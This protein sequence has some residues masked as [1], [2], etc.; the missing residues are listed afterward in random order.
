MP[1][2]SR[3]ITPWNFKRSCDEDTATDC[4]PPK[5]V[6][7]TCRCTGISCARRIK[8]DWHHLRNLTT[9]CFFLRRGDKNSRHDVIEDALSSNDVALS[10]L[11]A[12]GL[13]PYSA[14]TWWRNIGF[15]E[16]LR[17]LIM[18]FTLTC[19]CL[20]GQISLLHIVGIWQLPMKVQDE[21]DENSEQI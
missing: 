3:R 8:N 9:K 18:W 14:D 20:E 5:G 7:T 12:A 13:H 6:T 1:R 10:I 11:P 15:W 19:C 16:V 17:K 4:I 2:A 21:W